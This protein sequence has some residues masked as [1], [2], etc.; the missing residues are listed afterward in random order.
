[1]EQATID[2]V[3]SLIGQLQG[4]QREYLE[5]YFNEA[6]VWLL[7]ACNIVKYEKDTIFIR[8]NT[9]VENVYILVKGKVKLLDY[10][11]LGINYDYMWLEAVKTFGPMEI[12]LNLERYQTTLMTT[13]P[14]TMLVISKGK[15]EKWMKGDINALLLESNMMASYLLEQAR[16]ERIFI[17]M[18]GTDRVAYLLSQMYE[19]TAKDNVCTIKLTRQELSDCTGLSVKTIN[20]SI[21][22]LQ[23]ENYINR[24]GNKIVIH[25]EQ[26]V[27]MKDVIAQKVGQ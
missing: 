5:T 2:K 11:I 3:L 16:K 17:F 8:E 26:Y 27:R 25:E 18:Q 4:K 6:P 21:A 10:R 19:E 15:F 9:L 13:T 1:M 20:R 12:I 23:E 24:S 14:C 7:D 22:K